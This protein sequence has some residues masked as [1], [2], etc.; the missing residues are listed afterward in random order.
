MAQ[1]ALKRSI[2]GLSLKG[3]VT[4][5]EIHRLTGYQDVKKQ[6]PCWNETGQDMLEG[7]RTMDRFI[8]C[9]CPA[10][11]WKIPI[12]LFYISLYSDCGFC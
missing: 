12:V 2:L 9:F 8:L 1:Y 5:T 6:E 10:V 4:N 7:G 3:Q 11:D